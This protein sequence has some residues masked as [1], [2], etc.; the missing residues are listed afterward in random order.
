MRCK[1]QNNRM[2]RFSVM[3]TILFFS[4]Q[5]LAAQE[6]E[7]TEDWSRR[8][9]VITPGKKSQPPS[10]A[11]ILYAGKKEA[12]KWQH[13]KGDSIKWKTGRSLTVEASAGAIF[14]RE[15][16]GDIQL[17]I[18]WRSPKKV[19]GDGQGRGNSGIYLMGLYEVQVLD[20]Y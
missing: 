12:G 20:S 17:H 7:E 6:P 4:V 9:E 5:F 11:T 1:W 14:T 19:I 15:S 8:P 2:M 16:F 18:E 10:D 13:A 3:L